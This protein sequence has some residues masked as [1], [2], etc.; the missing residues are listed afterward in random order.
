MHRR[1]PAFFAASLG[2]MRLPIWAKGTNHNIGLRSLLGL[3]LL[4]A[5]PAVL[6]LPVSGL[7]SHAH[8]QARLPRELHKVSAGEV[9]AHFGGVRGKSLRDM[10]LEYAVT[11]LWFTFRGDRKRHVFRPAGE[12]FATDWRFDIFSPDG[13]RVLLL[14]D[15]FGPYHV[16]S[17]DKLRA[18]L[19][20]K[21]DPDQ[22]LTG[23]PAGSSPAGV[24][25][26]GRWTS[27]DTIEFK[28]TC[29]GETSIKQVKLDSPPR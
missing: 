9:T 1:L 28:F 25:H 7:V 23:A 6:P 21:I 15:R 29:C 18:Y 11:Q 13:R 2:A 20:R 22:V 3:A 26:D 14:Q 12:L 27:S 10:P 19:E 8:A 24:H 17:V 16:V 5:S 4:L